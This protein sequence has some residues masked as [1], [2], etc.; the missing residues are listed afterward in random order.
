MCCAQECVVA[1]AGIEAQVREAAAN[2]K[3][4]F[5]TMSASASS[6][7]IALL[8][9][10]SGAA[11]GPSTMPT[12]AS[13]L[14]MS[15]GGAPAPVSSAAGFGAGAGAAHYGSISS[16]LHYPSGF[17]SAVAVPYPHVAT[18]TPFMS[19]A[20]EAAAAG[21]GASAAQQAQQAGLQYPPGNAP[22]LYQPY[23]HV[24]PQVPLRTCFSMEPT[25]HLYGGPGGGGSAAA[26][27][28]SITAAVGST[29]GGPLDS[30]VAATEPP[31]FMSLA[32]S[33][34]N[35]Q[36]AAS[37][38]RSTTSTAQGEDTTAPATA[39]GAAPLQ[40]TP[41]LSQAAPRNTASLEAAGSSLSDA[42]MLVDGASQAEARGMQ[43]A[44]AP[45][46]FAAGPDV[47]NSL[48]FSIGSAALLPAVF[49]NNNIFA[50]LP[51]SSTAT[52]HAHVP[53]HTVGI[54]AGAGAAGSAAAP[55]AS[56][57]A[58]E[59]TE[60]AVSAATA[61]STG[62]ASVVDARPA[63]GSIA[64]SHATHM[65][66]NGPGQHFKRPNTGFDCAPAGAPL[67]VP[68][69]AS[70]PVFASAAPPS[71]RCDSDVAPSV[72]A[73]PP[74][75]L[76]GE[77]WVQSPIAG[78]TIGRLEQSLQGHAYASYADI[79]AQSASLFMACGSTGGRGY[80]MPTSSEPPCAGAT[81]APQHGGAAASAAAA[82][83]GRPP[84][85]LPAAALSSASA[86][87]CGTA[88]TALMTGMMTTYGGSAGLGSSTVWSSSMYGTS[89]PLHGTHVHTLPFYQAGAAGALA[90]AAAAAAAA[91]ATASAA[92]SAS[93]HAP[94][95]TDTAL[96]SPPM[97]QSTAPRQLQ[98]WH[99]QPQSQPQTPQS[100]T[101]T[102]QSQAPQQ[103]PA[104]K[105]PPPAQLY[106]SAGPS[107]E[108]ESSLPVSA[109]GFA[110]TSAGTDLSA[111]A[112]SS[113]VAAMLGSDAAVGPHGS[114]SPGAGGAVAARASPGVTPTRTPT[115]LGAAVANHHGGPSLSDRL[116][117]HRSGNRFGES[118]G[119]LFSVPEINSGSC[120]GF[121]APTFGAACGAR[122]A[123][124]SGS[125][126]SGGPR[127]LSGV[128]SPKHTPSAM[129]MHQM[130]VQM[131]MQTQL[132]MYQQHQH[133][134]QVVQ[135]MQQQ[136]MQHAATQQQ[137][138]Q[139]VPYPWYPPSAF[140]PTH[141]GR[142]FPGNG[143][144]LPTGASP[145]MSGNGSGGGG[146]EIAAAAEQ[147]HYSRSANAAAALTSTAQ[148]QAPAPG[149][150]AAAGSGSGG[151]FGYRTLPG[152]NS[153]GAWVTVRKLPVP[154]QYLGGAGSTGGANSFG[155]GGGPG[156]ILS[157]M[158]VP[159]HSMGSGRR[160]SSSTVLQH[161]PE[162]DGD[163]A[164]GA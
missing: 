160:G 54:A 157:A 82:G 56:S 16:Y 72:L 57:T 58:D 146:G 62:T 70:R 108:R 12:C 31:M 119:N 4:R 106:A 2:A 98:Q 24:Q 21:G 134:Q 113:A 161:V 5:A 111:N 41:A 158:P 129:Q 100:Q 137:Q 151:G 162:D 84:P 148:Q 71:F 117:P 29:I 121:N 44:P 144:A 159:M 1:L 103:R 17:P 133:Q 87:S 164:S 83:R 43:A 19:A 88:G 47:D 128:P 81:S 96:V 104:P 11:F 135:A 26:A 92:A 131:Q 101:Q 130:H 89:P 53:V 163:S 125:N 25:S 75:P 145:Y 124:N 156:G 6:R 55:T 155:G 37:A 77:P 48:C 46:A 27:A 139:Q 14:D 78:G 33:A 95:A 115:H 68:A 76:L 141:A 85:P 107:L 127:I 35:L 73:L 59:S 42:A 34:G 9:A 8:G 38:S 10:S 140:S 63:Y 138:Q 50:V 147:P 36:T 23:I 61:A 30:S 67:A 60:G 94:V 114:S 149:A 153:N 20:W 3:Q 7:G 13:T 45:A 132:Q 99:S 32:H 150:P 15:C 120:D 39:S 90:T 154:A 105:I 18:A 86:A 91:A 52:N 97:Q 66:N 118:P 22:Y 123:D 116:L 126:G 69:S 93:C 40:Q 122:G 143:F 28:G 80:C 152:Y 65:G 79:A 102:Q 136:G 64:A 49:G 109:G 51:D 112:T 142:G 110:A 74:S